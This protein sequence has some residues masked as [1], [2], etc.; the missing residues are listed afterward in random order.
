MT[1]RLLDISHR[2]NRSYF[3]PGISVHRSKG[4]ACFP[5]FA[6]SAAGCVL[7]DV[8]G[9]TFTD[10]LMGWGCHLLGYSE[11]RVVEAVQQA[12]AAGGGVLSLPHRLEMEVTELVCSRFPWGEE[13]IFGKS[14]SDVTTWAVR[15]A[16][17]ATGRKVVLG[18]GYF[19]WADW[20]AGMQGIGKTGVPAG[21]N[22]YFVPL[23]F[24][25]IAALEAAAAKHGGGIWRRS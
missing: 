19:G 25:D 8:D 9:T 4:E 2:R 5:V 14:G 12:V 16:R 10:V 18:A 13:A 22:A 20:F 21:N 15:M 6:E 3:S 24:L 11:P 23:P 7:T 1:D 17:V